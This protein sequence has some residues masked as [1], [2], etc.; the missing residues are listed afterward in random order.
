MPAANPG[1]PEPAALRAKAEQGDP[2]AQNAL[3]NLY[4]AGQG[5][6]QDFA[7]AMKWYRAAGEKGS[8]AAQF[9][10]GLAYEMGRGVLGQKLSTSLHKL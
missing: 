3:G 2:D 7:E 6:A 9:N 1:A 10:L 5:V 8:A 4:T